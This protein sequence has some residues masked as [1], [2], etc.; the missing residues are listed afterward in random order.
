MVRGYHAA[1]L[2]AITLRCSVHSGELGAHMQVAQLEKSVSSLQTGKVTIS[3]ESSD[4]VEKKL[5]EYISAWQ[6]RKR[7]FKDVWC[8]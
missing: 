2:V 7:M 8:E 5:S 4:A 1:V 3:K 6:R